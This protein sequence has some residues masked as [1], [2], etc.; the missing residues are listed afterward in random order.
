MNK[1]EERQS[2][3]RGTHSSRLSRTKSR[4]YNTLPPRERSGEASVPLS[5]RIP[6][7]PIAPPFAILLFRIAILDP[8][9][10]QTLTARKPAVFIYD[11]ETPPF[12]IFIILPQVGAGFCAYYVVGRALSFSLFLSFYLSILLGPCEAISFFW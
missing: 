7:P 8:L 10:P 5:F 1:R 2:I 11:I 9:S 6:P 4:D 12:C 3:L